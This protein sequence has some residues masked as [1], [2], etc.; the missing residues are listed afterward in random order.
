MS[1]ATPTECTQTDMQHRVSREKNVCSPRGI[2]RTVS[3]KLRKE[4]EEMKGE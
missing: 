2:R 1:W 3:G 4:R